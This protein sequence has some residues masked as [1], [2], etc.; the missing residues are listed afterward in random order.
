MLLGRVKAECSFLFVC[1]HHTLNFCCCSALRAFLPFLS[2][3][4]LSLPALSMCCCFFQVVSFGRFRFFWPQ[5]F[6]D[7]IFPSLSWSS[8]W[9]VRF[10]SI[11]LF[12]LSSAD[13]WTM[14]FSVPFSTSSF[15]EPLSSIT[16][17]FSSCVLLL[18]LCFV[19][20]FRSNLLL[21][22]RLCRFLHLYLPGRR[23]HCPGHNL[24]SVLN[25]LLFLHQ[26]HSANSSSFGMEFPRRQP[27][28]SH[29]NKICFDV[30]WT[31]ALFRESF[32]L[33]A[34]MYS[35]FQYSEYGVRTANSWMAEHSAS[36]YLS[37]LP[38]APLISTV[39]LFRLLIFTDLPQGVSPYNVGGDRNRVF[40]MSFAAK[41]RRRKLSTKTTFFFEIYITHRAGKQHHNV[42]TFDFVYVARF[43]IDNKHAQ[44]YFPQPRKPFEMARLH[45]LKILFSHNWKKH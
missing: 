5:T 28:F 31:N 38:M 44:R 35:G 41:P 1:A 43:R 8:H 23:R 27:H 10:D 14:Q 12:Y 39:Q 25:L 20:C 22:F 42:L 9:S 37:D 3:L 2:I 34:R 32:E 15:G 18:L 29:L 4:F 45:F 40:S 16:S 17:L 26:W 21:Q 33:L 30:I 6:V 36:T 19:W 24:S 11:Q 7:F 13:G